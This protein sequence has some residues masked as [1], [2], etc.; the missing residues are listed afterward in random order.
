M[1][2]ERNG[3]FYIKLPLLSSD[4][5]TVLYLMKQPTQ[6]KRLTRLDNNLM[7][8]C[9]STKFIEVSINVIASLPTA[10]Q[11]KTTG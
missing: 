5:D 11:I 9:N 6:Q 2:P 10:V 1:H 8:Q 3:E 4:L 7:I